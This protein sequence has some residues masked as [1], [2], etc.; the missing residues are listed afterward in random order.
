MSLTLRVP[1]Y[2]SIELK[3]FVSIGD[4]IHNIVAVSLEERKQKRRCE[5]KNNRGILS[6]IVVRIR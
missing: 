2:R 1:Y 4:L 6:N 5:S 3:E